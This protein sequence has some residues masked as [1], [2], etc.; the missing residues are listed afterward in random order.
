MSTHVRLRILNVVLIG[1]WAASLGAVAGCDCGNSDAT[2]VRFGGGSE[3]EETDLPFC[4]PG[5][6]PLKGYVLTPGGVVAVPEASVAATDAGVEV[7]A[8]SKGYFEFE[9]L[10]GGEQPLFA[11]KGEYTGSANAMIC[12]DEENR[13]DITVKPEDQ[14]IAVIWGTYDSV[15]DILSEMG[16]VEGTDFDIFDA[17]FLANA[18]LISQYDYVFINCTSS[19]YT[20]EGVDGVGGGEELDAEVINQNLLSF[21]D[22]GGRLYASDWSFEYIEN[23]W[24]EAVTFADEDGTGPYL[25]EADYTV[26][27]DIM[28]AQLVAYLDKSTVE[29][30]FN[31]VAW[32]VMETAGEGTNVLVQGDVTAGTE[33]PDAPLLVQFDH[34]EGRVTYTSFHDEAQA[35]GDMQAMLSYLVF[36]L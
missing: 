29:I 12:I 9:E 3:E 23:V 16:Y 4:E 1:L 17:S 13:Q 21:V 24:P 33:F 36:N 20:N 34:G 27:G 26:L 5:P 30:Y 14:A 18:E 32:I 8:D 31:L 2:G 28:D 10:P 35:T 15:Q 7:V 6:G 25:G 22:N 11:S 19:P